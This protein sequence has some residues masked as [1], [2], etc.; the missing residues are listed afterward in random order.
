VVTRQFRVLYRDFLFSIV[1]RE[2][3]S[4]HARGDASQLLLQLVTLLGCL[5][6]CFCLP[7]LSI[8]AANETAYGRLAFAWSIE[9]FLIAT[10]ML[11]VGVFAVLSWDSMFPSQ[12]DVLVLGPLPIRAHTILLARFCAVASALCLTVFTFHVATGAIWP[13]A[14]NGTVR[15]GAIHAPRYTGDAAM[16]PVAAADL[17]AV[18]DDDLVDAI[19]NGPLAPGA[20]GGVSIGVY[21]RGVR[22]IFTYG[23]AAPD[24]IFQIGS[25]TKPFTGLLLADMVERGLVEI[26]APVRD[27][28]QATGLPRPVG[29]EITLI[30]LV[31]HRSGLPGMPASFRRAANP[32]NPVAD[33]D[34]S[35]LYAFLR[36]RG[37]ER[38]ADAPYVYSNLGFGLLGHAL[39]RR[40][41]VDYAALVREAITGP[42]A[43]NDT[44]VELS[45]EQQRRLIQGY[46]DY[47]RPIPAWDFDVLAGAG[48]LRSTAPDMLK[49]LEAN[50]HPERIR[51]GA[52]SA[53]LASSHQIRSSIDAH[54]DLALAWMYHPDS[55]DF[56][57]AG[58]LLAFTAHTFFNPKEDV[59][60][61]VLSN[62]GPGT[63]I[64]ADAVS[65]HVRA[66][67]DGRPA[68]SLAEVMIPAAGGVRTWIRLL[69][70]YWITMT[71]AAVFVFGLAMSAQGLAAAVLP[72]RHFHRASSLLQLVT[73]CLVVGT[74]FLQ[75][76]LIRPDVVQAAQ[77]GGP[78]AWSPSLWFL[79]LFQELSGSP[80]L[81][82]LG[83]RAWVGVG[84]SVFCTAIAYA[85]SY[86]R[87]LRQIAEQPDVAAPVARVRWLMECG[88]SFQTALVQFS[89]RTVFRS[90]PH[91]V[92]LAF[93]WGIAFALVIIFVKSPGGQQFTDFSLVSDWL[94]MSVPLLVSSMVM[95]AFAVLAGRLAFAMPVDLKANWIF[96]V[97]PVRAGR[98]YTSAR[99]P[100]L[101]MLSAAPVWTA[102][103]VALFWLWPWQPALGHLVALAFLGL[104]LVEI[105][106]IGPVKIP[107]TCSYLPGKSHVH[108]A[109]FAACVLLLPAVFKAATFERDALQDLT[110]YAAMVAGLCATWIGLRWR[111]A[112]ADAQASQPVFDDEPVGRAVTLE[113][114]DSRAS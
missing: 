84:L 93:Y 41:G 24:S 75:P 42:L 51:S 78:L 13:L 31:T 107:C 62:V 52:L 29:D 91:R 6:V 32:S 36:A 9:H 96:R 67:L 82:P 74:Y 3:L 77:S 76:M 64:S 16:P 23:A 60:V 104:I 26:D 63:A 88:T 80:A 81:A 109:V 45:P 73:F 59:A 28:I 102:W 69:I 34:V 46:N 54:T 101:V 12:R 50:L 11:V 100:A 14:L 111:T 108:L 70:A 1:D 83:R 79:G 48:G 7:V 30:D 95:M 113:L 27:L 43:M 105:A 10:T 61:V 25:A 18:L 15:G 19:R 66:R 5:S 85:L 47:R 98:L 22:R 65:A 92:I 71:T 72:R 89:V 86:V 114:W 103:A 57:H 106:L 99:R 56:E 21:Q 87:T 2:L 38:R 112:V 33:F 44:A 40:A 8:G 55:G 20:A 94:E 53:A 110:R 49:W 35:R 17:Q 58:A 4:T 37:L 68:V 39:S 90:A 97:M